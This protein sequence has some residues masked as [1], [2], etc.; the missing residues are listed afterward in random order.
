[1]AL[2]LKLANFVFFL[3]KDLGTIKPLALLEKEI[4]TIKFWRVLLQVTDY[5]LK[6]VLI[7]S[8]F[9]SIGKCAYHLWTKDLGYLQHARW[10]E[11]T[12]KF[13]AHLK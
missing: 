9:R 8:S 6:L 13:L 12:M 2:A 4:C 7:H 1:M 3:V 11:R 5:A 10:S